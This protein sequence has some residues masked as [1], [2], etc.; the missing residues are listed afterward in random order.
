[1]EL[2]GHLAYRD[3]Q[4][5]EPRWGTF[6]TLVEN[7][8]IYLWG[9]HHNMVLL[10]RVRVGLVLSRSAYEFWN[11]EEYT[12]DP[13]SAA[14]IFMNTQHGGIFRSNLFAPDSG[15]RYVFIGVSADG[16]SKINMGCSKTLEGPFEMFKIADA[17]GLTQDGYTYCIYPHPWACR[18]EDGDVLVTWSEAWPGGVVA[19][20]LRFQMGEALPR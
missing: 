16:D 17:R 14:P 2:D 10:A 11:G 5:H 18:E 20:R 3:M 13:R 8:Y 12:I 4:A 1:M 6:S 19:S 9:H 15:I 7:G